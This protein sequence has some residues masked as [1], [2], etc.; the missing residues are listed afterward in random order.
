MEEEPIT[1]EDNKIKKHFKENKVAYIAGS[2]GVLVGALGGGAFVLTR[3]SGN[4]AIVDSLKLI[5][6]KSSHISKTIQV[7]L[8]RRG[9]PGFIIARNS[10]GERWGSIKSAA[11]AIGCNPSLLRE[12]L[13]GL[14]PDINGE[15]YTN[16]GE[17]LGAAVNISAA[18]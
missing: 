18:N 16:L 6:W 4:V 2:V 13:A 9:H 1:K 15:T 10:D 14:V 11:E 17:N 12:H 7:A 3:L 5:N 8:P